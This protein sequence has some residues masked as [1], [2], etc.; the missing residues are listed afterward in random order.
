VKRLQQA[1]RWP[2][3]RATLAQAEARLEGSGPDDLEARQ[4]LAATRDF[5]A[6]LPAGHPQ[7]HAAQKLLRRCERVV[8]LENRLPAILRGE[9]RPADAKE[10]LEFA[11]MCRRPGKRLYAASAR[12]YA[13]AFTAEPNLATP[14]HLYQAARAAAMTGCG[15][16]YDGAPGEKGWARFREPA[17]TWLKADLALHAKQMEGTAAQEALRWWQNDPDLA[18]VR[19]PA[20]LAKAG[21]EKPGR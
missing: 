5:L 21:A 15:E 12:F 20:A 9:D 1:A 13:D 11:A 19:D 16:G 3:A 14:L 2:E 4:A 7:R 10:Q 17:L 18:G 6:L 8:A